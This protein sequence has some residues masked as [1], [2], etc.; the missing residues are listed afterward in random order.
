MIIYKDEE[1]FE[2]AQESY[3]ESEIQWHQSKGMVISDS[4]IEEIG[5][6]LNIS[7]EKVV[8]L[9]ERSV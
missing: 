8:K 7:K 2:N 3:V 1:S 4:L 9:I 6:E 5:R